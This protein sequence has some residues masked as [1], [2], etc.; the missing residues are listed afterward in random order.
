MKTKNNSCNIFTLIEL[1]V[2]IAIIAILA[3][4]LLPALNKARDKAKAIGCASNLK[5]IGVAS[6][7]Y[8]DDNDGYLMRIYYGSS[9]SSS[10]WWPAKFEKYYG[11][12]AKLICPSRGGGINWLMGYAL[13][14]NV[15]YLKFVKVK[16]PSEK[17]YIADSTWDGNKYGWALYGYKIRYDETGTRS[18]IMMRH[19]NNRQANVLH[20][21]GHVTNY[22]DSY[23]KS[24]S[25]YKIFW[26][27]VY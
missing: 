24:F 18:S 5:Q 1:L 21:D 4:M 8:I 23:F 12:Q 14:T 17:G 11:E 26:D 16:S 25:T 13:S 27:P 9:S 20:H 19:G 10:S 15:G 22:N 3:A 6:S 7:L 2:V